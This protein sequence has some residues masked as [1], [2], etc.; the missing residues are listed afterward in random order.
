MMGLGE[1]EFRPERQKYWGRHLTEVTRENKYLSLC[2]ERALSHLTPFVWY[3]W[4]VWTRSMHAN[5]IC[6]FIYRVL[7]LLC[8]FFG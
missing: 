7:C 1:E 8:F 4:I 6:H 2:I 3:Q 5:D